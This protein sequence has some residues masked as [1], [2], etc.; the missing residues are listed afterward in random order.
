MTATRRWWKA[1][2][3]FMMKASE[4]LLHAVLTEAI[5]SSLLWCGVLQASLS[6]LPETAKSSGER[7]GLELGQKLEGQKPAKFSCS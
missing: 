7:S 5:N 1:L 2:H 3:E 4:R 6:N